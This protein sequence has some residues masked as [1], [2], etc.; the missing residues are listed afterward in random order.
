M[1]NSSWPAARK[2]T[3]FDGGLAGRL[4]AIANGSATSTTWGLRAETETSNSGWKKFDARTARLV[5]GVNTRP[6][7]PDT[8]MVDSRPCAAG[9]GRP[10]IATATPVLK[11]RVTDPDGHSM[12]AWYAWAKWNGSSFV[13][14]GGDHNSPHANGAYAET[15]TG[16]LEH[17]GVYT[18]RMA[19]ND[20]PS[21][22]GAWGVSD[23]TH[24]PGNC[25]WEVDLQD[26]VVPTVSGDIYQQN[27]AGCPPQGCGSV[28]QTGRFTFSSSADVVA[29]RWGLTS[30]PTTVLNASAGGT[31][32]LDWTPPD[33]GA[34]TLHV[35]A[36]D[37]AGR[38]ATKVYQ[39]T[40]AP[41][42]TA[43]ARW[44]LDEYP[45]ATELTD[46][47]GNGWTATPFGNPVLGADGRLRPGL[48]GATRTAVGFDGVDDYVTASE[49][50]M[51]DTSRSFSVA[52]WARVDDTGVYR[53]VIGQG[54][55]ANSTFWIDAT[56]AGRWRFM[57]TAADSATSAGLSAQSTSVVRA[58]VWTHLAAVYDSAAKTMT[59]YVNGVAE[60]TAS[61]VTTW[62]GIRPL[63]IS[64]SMRPWKGAVAELQVW[65]RVI[66][67]SEVFNLVDPIVVGKVGEW[68]MDEVG[69]G[70]A[71]DASGMARDLNFYGGAEIPA[72]GA[73]QSGTGLRLDGVDDYVTPDLPVLRT[74]QSLTISA[75]AKLGP[76]AN[77]DQVVVNQGTVSLFVRGLE[78]K[79][80]M[81]VQTPN[82][83]GGYINSEAKSNVAAVP[84][85]WVHLVGV[86]DASTGQVRL[87]VNG[88]LQTAVANGAT[89]QD[90]GQALTIGA[91]GTNLLFGGDIDEVR[92]FQGVVT[93][94]T[95]I[96]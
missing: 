56:D 42:S 41:P 10:V 66:S 65:D 31:A 88:V 80:G 30:P 40:V 15:T 9:A 93:D 14:V 54:G 71:F 26:P 23:V 29:F 45:G 62:D 47:T 34:K 12:E 21:V 13:D 74:N 20:G 91:K 68:H 75:W 6:N 22:S 11:G 60:G 7:T 32:T 70:P 57:T 73:G 5:V 78:G 39:F 46:D 1:T 94:V 61:G 96:P 87:Y 92:V 28:G 16:T 50:A 83:S 81:T 77:R 63:R 8:L 79:W 38:T 36:I 25:E 49:G 51:P 69:P 24:M 53:T 55:T 84:G 44:K 95:R 64:G 90:A 17:G 33:G 18:F 19:T 72:S 86:F 89:G 52:V 27:N 43:A 85:V 4:Q 3:E 82:G 76:V 59:L 58:G 48:D 2:L 37:R 35:Q 67:T